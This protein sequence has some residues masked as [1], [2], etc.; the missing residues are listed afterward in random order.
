[1]GHWVTWGYRP[2]RTKIGEDFQN[3]WEIDSI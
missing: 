1:M 2:L 3:V